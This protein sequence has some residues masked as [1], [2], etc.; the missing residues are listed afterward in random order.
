MFKMTFFLQT[1][2]VHIYLYV[3]ILNKKWSWRKAIKLSVMQK[4]IIETNNGM[5][6]SFSWLDILHVK[7][8]VKFWSYY[9]FL[10]NFT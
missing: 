8:K 3:K 5:M 7:L 6:Y 9:L 1:Y 10:N 2:Q 4:R